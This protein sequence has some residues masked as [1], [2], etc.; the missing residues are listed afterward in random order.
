VP[1]DADDCADQQ[2]PA[3]HSQ[4]RVEAQVG[5]FATSSMV[6][7][8]GQ[9]GFRTAL[10]GRTTSEESTPSSGGDRPR[11]GQ[12]GDGALAM[13]CRHDDYAFLPP[14]ARAGI[15]CDSQTTADQVDPQSVA[16]SMFDRL[17][18]PDLRIGMNPRL[19]LVAVPTWFW[20]EGYS[21][22]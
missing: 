16:R 12:T 7:D 18:L 11:N 13:Y 8:L 5:A 19:G 14:D 1:G 20:V 15:P 3:C 4:R 17:D 9:K 2:A 22:D 6:D 21:G 10:T